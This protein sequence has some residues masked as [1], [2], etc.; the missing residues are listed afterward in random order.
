MSTETLQKFKDRQH[1]EVKRSFPY[2][3]NKINPVT[4]W[5]DSAYIDDNAIRYNKRN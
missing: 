5:V 3:D 4:G 2:W 1:K